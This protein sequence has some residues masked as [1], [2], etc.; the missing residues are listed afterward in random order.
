MKLS[1][2]ERAL[3]QMK[4]LLNRTAALLALGMFAVY[5]ALA[6][7]IA[8]YLRL[9]R[10]ERAL[11]GLEPQ[12]SVEKATVQLSQH[13]VLVG[14]QSELIQGAVL[15]VASLAIGYALHSLTRP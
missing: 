10:V 3:G 15:V 4:P 7:S 2:L 14:Q 8:R 13:L 1:G 6:L 5:S 12:S 9:E 11:A